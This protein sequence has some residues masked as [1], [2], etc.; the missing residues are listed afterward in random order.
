[1]RLL[2]NSLLSIPGHEMKNMDATL[3]LGG[4]GLMVRTVEHDTGLPMD[5]YIA[6]NL[7]GFVKV[8]D[9]LGGVN[10]CVPHAVNDRYS[11]LRMS[12]GL[13]HVNGITA[14]KY[15]RDRH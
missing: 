10:I 1:M 7:L 11:G 6:V 12:A 15:A 8:I 2:H 14:L 13:H 4:L 3:G 9:A 5:E